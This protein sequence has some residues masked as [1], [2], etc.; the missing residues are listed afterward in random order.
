MKGLPKNVGKV[1]S[2]IGSNYCVSLWHLRQE[3]YHH[4]LLYKFHMDCLALIHEQGLD[5]Y[6]QPADVAIL[7]SWV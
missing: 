7:C 5:H 3:K 4:S 1:R 2:E 6:L